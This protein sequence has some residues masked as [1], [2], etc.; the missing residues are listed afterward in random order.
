[1]N[2]TQLKYFNAI[3]SLNSVSA[4]AD[5]LFVSQPT[6]SNAIKELEEEFGI[7]LFK[8]HH[9]GMSLTKE[10]ELLY[11][12]SKDLLNRAEHIQKVMNDLGKNRKTLRLGVPPM[13]GSM[14]LPLIHGEFKKEHP[15]IL[16]E[17]SEGGKAELLD[18]LE[19]DYLDMIFLSH[20]EKFPPDLS[21]IYIESVETVLCVSE[22]NPLSKKKS[23]TPKDL[24]DTPLVLFKNSF[25]QTELIKKSFFDYNLSPN[26]LLQTEQL[27][28][29]LNMISSNM[30]AG[31]LFEPLIKSGQGIVAIPMEKRLFADISLVWKK[32]SY[33]FTGMKTFSDFIEN[34]R[35]L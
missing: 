18:K 33:I 8:R 5:F 4:A 17:I 15:E 24:K 26:I 19:N 13:I 12:M 31:F 7:T 27:S 25:F 14:Y 28:N 35:K 2:I 23:V 11:N 6:I 21:S 30:S 9:R 29:I 3:C 22:K 16:L 32:D 20:N 10:G 1:M 34:H